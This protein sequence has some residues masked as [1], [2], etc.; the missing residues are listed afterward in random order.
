[1][2]QAVPEETREQTALPV[3]PAWLV[4]VRLPL[5]KRPPP[6]EAEAQAQVPPGAEAAEDPEPAAQEEPTL[7]PEQTAMP[8][9]M[10]AQEA[11]P[12]EREEQP[13]A[14]AELPL[15]LPMGAPTFLMPQVVCLQVQEEAEDQVAVEAEGQAPTLP[16]E[17]GKR[18][19]QAEAEAELSPSLLQSFPTAA[20][21]PVMA[22]PVQPEAV[23]QQEQPVSVRATAV[24]PEE[25]EQAEKAVVVPE[26]RSGF[27]LQP[28][29]WVQ[30]LPQEGQLVQGEQEET[31]DTATMEQ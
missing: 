5:T 7:P 1:M 25:A 18:E 4:K 10:E 23:A 29:L 21:L 2:A 13:E 6:E 30:L 14:L 3:P 16:A 12:A 24:V 17:Q 28:S 26:G 31:E 22:M 15:P 19:V 8:A 11:I 20:L 27:L 9:P